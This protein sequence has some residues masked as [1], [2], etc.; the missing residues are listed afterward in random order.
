[1]M[2]DAYLNKRL[3]ENGKESGFGFSY[4]LIVKSLT[5]I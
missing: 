5:T 3:S 1:M 4:N 2:G